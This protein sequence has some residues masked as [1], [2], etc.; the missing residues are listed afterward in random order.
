MYIVVFL[1]IVTNHNHKKGREG[2]RHETIMLQKLSIMLLKK[3][4]IMLL[5]IAKIMPP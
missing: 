2:S 3:S 4:P 1:A 5:R